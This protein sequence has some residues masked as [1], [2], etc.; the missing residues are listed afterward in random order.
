VSQ[1]GQITQKK[2]KWKAYKAIISTGSVGSYVKPLARSDLGNHLWVGIK[3]EEK[4]KV[5]SLF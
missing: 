1:K 5:Y 2:G 3:K 4:N